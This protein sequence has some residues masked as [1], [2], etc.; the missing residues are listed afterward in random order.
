MLEGIT[1][2]IHVVIVVIGVGEELIFVA[3]NKVIGN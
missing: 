3:K 1:I 2:V